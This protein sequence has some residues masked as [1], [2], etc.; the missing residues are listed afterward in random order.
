MQS[1]RHAAGALLLAVSL[2]GCQSPHA[3]GTVSPSSTATKA[4]PA[5]PP[6][7]ASQRR[8]EGHARYAHAVLLELNEEPETAALEYHRAALLDPANEA[9]VLEASGK[10]LRLKMTGPAMELLKRAAREPSVTPAILVRLATAH[11]VLTNKPEAIR[12]CRAAARKDPRYFPAYHQWAQIHLQD[13]EWTAG[14]NVLD[15][16][17]RVRDVDPAFLIDLSG[18]YMS[19]DRA[20]ATNQTRAKALALLQRAARYNPENPLLLQRLADGFEALG[21]SARAIEFTEKLR[22]RYPGLPGWNQKLVDLYLSAEDTTNA[23]TLL[24]EMVRQSPTDPRPYFS[25]GKIAMHEQRPAD[26]IEHFEKVILLRPDF[27][28]AYYELALAQLAAGRSHTALATLSQARSQFPKSFALEFYSGIAYG[29]LKDY[30]RAVQHLTT[31]EV[32]ARA[33]DTNRLTAGF[34]FQLGSAHERNQQF[35]EA[36]RCFRQAL[37]LQPDFSEA[38]NY[39]G[40]MWA[41]RGENLEEALQLIEKAVRLEPDNAAYLDS[42]GWVLFKLNKPQEALP[43]LLKALDHLEEPDATIYDHLGDVYTALNQ[44]EK[45]REA[46]TKALA[47]ESS[48][49]KEQV[50]KKLEQHTAPSP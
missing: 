26:A 50:R 17:A 28:P 36:T 34:Y 37:A 12:H 42:L 5:H 11:L 25:L 14:L 2:A 15:Q 41:E 6:D 8:S 44:K 31:A 9:V 23:A 22:Q 1:I 35:G 7:S 20:G 16:A 3:T 38:L 48:E 46:W 24:L 33:T 30:R 40:Y 21:D 13:R 47:I 10:L 18:L 19:F 43:H 4:I 39:L 32:I 27:E 49:I 29:R 45:A